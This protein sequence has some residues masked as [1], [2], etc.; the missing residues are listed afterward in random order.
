LLG[1]TN[2]AYILESSSDLRTWTRALTNAESQTTRTV[3]VPA[4]NA[5]TFCRVRHVPRPLF[6][7]AI[8]AQGTV[9]LFGSGRID[10]FNSTNLAESNMGQYDPATATDRALV[11]T[12]LR[13]IEAIYVGTMAIYGSV[14]TG[15]GGTVQIANSGSVGSKAW[16]ESPVGKGRVEPDHH[17]ND[18]NYYIPPARL[19][20]DF[21]PGALPQNVLYPVVGGIN[22]QYAILADGD[23]RHIGNISLGSGQKMLI[24]A[25]CRIHV[26]GLFTVSSSGYVL[27]NT[28]AYVEFYCSSRVDIQ[29]QGF[30]NLNGYARNFSIIALSSQPVSYGGQARLIGTFYAPLSTVTLVGTTDAIGAFTCN[31]FSLGG[32][33]GIHFDES[34]K[35]AGPFY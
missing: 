7:H 32:T 10:S 12:T 5:Q 9:N 11:G 4:T 25:R 28:N 17:I 34:L 8:V 29:G 27:M 20:N 23:Y 14:A 18:V 13:T 30:I 22:Y 16:V 24:N 19:P 2:V 15:P 3:I 6:E 35:S 33:M 31:N 26:T 21:G 1:E